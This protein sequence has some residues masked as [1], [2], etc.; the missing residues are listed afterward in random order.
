ML[1]VITSVLHDFHVRWY[2]TSG[3]GTA[4]PSANPELI[5]VLWKVP[6]VVSL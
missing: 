3:A 4:E 2:I 1:F 5:P 6:V